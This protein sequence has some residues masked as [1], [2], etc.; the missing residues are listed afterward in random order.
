MPKVV[1]VPLRSDNWMVGEATGGEPR[2]MEGGIFAFL[3]SHQF[4][5][6]IQ[7][8]ANSRTTKISLL[9]QLAAI[10]TGVF[11]QNVVGRGCICVLRFW[12]TA[13]TRGGSQICRPPGPIAYVRI[14][15]NQ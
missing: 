13:L 2:G 9:C 15:N 10:F 6:F 4:D 14:I 7:P 11:G 5:V 8:I 3:K 12:K 1:S